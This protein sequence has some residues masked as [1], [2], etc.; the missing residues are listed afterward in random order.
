M[1]RSQIWAF[2]WHICIWL[3]SIIKVKVRSRLCI[4]QLRLDIIHRILAN[5]PKIMK[6]TGCIHNH[7]PI[8]KCRNLINR[9]TTRD[10]WRFR[11]PGN[12]YSLFRLQFTIAMF[13]LTRHMWHCLLFSIQ[14]WPH[15]LGTL[16]G[17]RLARSKAQSVLSLSQAAVIVASHTTQQQLGAGEEGAR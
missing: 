12:K 10:E 2:H 4:I 5:L 1:L 8:K 11:S 14:L 15:R 13:A 3:W 16:C 9:K 7:I 17:S 6:E